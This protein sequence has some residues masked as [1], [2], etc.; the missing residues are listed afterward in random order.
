MVV[1]LIGLAIL[2]P[3][4]NFRG[5]R[6]LKIFKNPCAVMD[7]T[8]G[9]LLAAGFLLFMGAGFLYMGFFV[10]EAE[11]DWG[12]IP[13]LI[14]TAVAVGIVE[15]VFFRG[16]I[17]GICLRR[18]KVLNAVILTSGLFALIHFLK[19]KLKIA[20]HEVTWTTGLDA[21]GLAFSQ[22]QDLPAVTAQFLT[23]F[24]LGVVL[25]I[26]RLRTRSLWLPMGL[27]AGWVLGYE[28]FKKNTDASASI[29]QWAPWVGADLKIGVIP[30]II[31][32]ITGALASLWIDLSRRPIYED[33]PSSQD[34]E[35]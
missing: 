13:K 31:I 34:Q 27:H 29:A 23:L 5:W 28:L 10:P 22:F 6:D 35:T 20:D 15:E 25:A 2:I 4:L 8:A 33:T 3:S 14:L 1:A 32:A 24:A 7:V 19:P 12:I 18:M 21:L 17:L 30:L 11:A 16:A 9:V 26:T